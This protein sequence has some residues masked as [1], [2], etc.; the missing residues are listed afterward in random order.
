MFD[1]MIENNPDLKDSF[2]EAFPNPEDIE[3]IKDLI[4]GEKTVSELL[5]TGQC[6]PMAHVNKVVENF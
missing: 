3:F 4:K 6:Q 1:Y 5:C 2:Q